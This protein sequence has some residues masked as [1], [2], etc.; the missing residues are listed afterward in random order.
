MG[1]GCYPEKR[2][3]HTN[4]Y[5]MRA[6]GNRAFETMPRKVRDFLK[7]V[8]LEAENELQDDGR[9]VVSAMTD[10]I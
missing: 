3:K 8:S 9:V 4:A 2:R 10:D 7:T 6:L 1:E 5:T